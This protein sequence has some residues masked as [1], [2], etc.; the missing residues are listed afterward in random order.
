MAQSGRAADAGGVAVAGFGVD[1]FGM[2]LAGGG[3][4]VVVGTTGGRPGS[5]VVVERGGGGAVVGV[6]GIGPCIGIP[7]LAERAGGPPRGC[8]AK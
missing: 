4:V 7:T 3:A 6:V 2:V 1:G 8:V 5:K